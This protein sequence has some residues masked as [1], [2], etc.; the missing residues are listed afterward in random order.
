MKK[1]LAVLLGCVFIV[2]IG[3]GITLPVLPFY[4]ERLAEAGGASRQSVVL[5]VGLLTGVYAL[6]QLFFAPVW[7]RWSDRIGRKPVIVIGIAG[8]A[9]AQVLFGLANSLWLLYT[10]RIVGG[11]M[12]SAA[13]PVTSAYVADMTTDKERAR[14]MAWFGTAV[15]LGV[16]VGPAFGGLLSRK[17]VHIYWQYGH[18]LLDGFS[19]P[20]FVAAILGLVAL[21]GAIRWL[22]ESLRI[23]PQR[24]PNRFSS[25]WLG[26]VKTL[27]PLLALALAAQFALALFEGTFPLFAQTV[28]KYGPVR[29][30]MVFVVCG[31]VMSVVQT[32]A[33]SLL[34]GRVSERAQIGV[35]FALMGIGIT[36]LASARRTFSVLTAVGL[37]SAGIAVIAPNIAALTS[38]RGSD[39][40]GAAL[41]VQ[42]AASSIGQA[43]GPVLGSVLFV[44]QLEAPFWIAGVGMALIA[45][46]IARSGKWDTRLDAAQPP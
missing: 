14:G 31:L 32:A 10:A 16:V 11:A 41:G 21:V 40:T 20:F 24:G 38:R 28:L 9:L 42:S 6:M 22:P 39:Q 44:W 4:V 30:G 46:L 18:L 1:H 34:A 37:T 36:L 8:Y 12:S 29:V 33:T 19:I 26:L 17:S 43:A 45:L 2:M 3:F 15:S 25:D 35:G 5:H 27:L 7:G 23:P 13:L